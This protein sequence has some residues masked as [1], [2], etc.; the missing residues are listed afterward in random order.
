MFERVKNRVQNH[1]FPSPRNHNFTTTPL[2]PVAI[3]RKH[4]SLDT[5]PTCPTPSLS[6]NPIAQLV[7]ALIV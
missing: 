1:S 5:T 6:P 4:C 7:R 3:H 2:H